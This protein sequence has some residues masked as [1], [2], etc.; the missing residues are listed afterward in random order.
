M[1]KKNEF[2]RRTFLQLAG[3]TA[4]GAALTACA[5]VASPQST[6]A[7]E[8]AAGAENILL[9]IQGN[10]ER[11]GPTGLLFTEVN[12]E[13]EIEF[14]SVTGIDHEEV[15]SKLLSMVAAG[16]PVDGGH[17]CTEATQLYAGQGLSVKL[18]DYILGDEDELMDYFADVSPPLIEAMFY[19]GSLY[20]LARDFNA[21]NMYY[22]TQLFEEAGYGHPESTWTKDDFYEI[23][24]AVT[25]KN[26][27][28]ETEVFGY[29]WIN[30]LWGSWMP[31]IF[32]NEGNLFVEERVEGGEWFW[33][34]FYADDPAA[35]GR[36]GGF[37]WREPVANQTANVEALEFMV[38]LFDEGIAPAV[39]L[40]GG[41]TLQGFFTSNRLAMT[42][43]GGFW[44]GGMHNAGLAPDA[45]DTQLWP[46]WK[47]Q[48][49]QFGV[50]AK[51]MFEQSENKD[52]MWEYMKFEVSEDG[53]KISGYF[54]PFILTTPCRRSMCNEEAFAETGP[55]HWQTFYDTLDKHPTT[56]PIPAPPIA[57]PMTTLFTSYTSR[58]MNKEMTPQE[59]LDGMQDEIVQL[60]D[61]SQDIMYPES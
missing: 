19:E 57:N 58:A 2:S 39:E 43:A 9:R 15:A 28:G 13:V 25:K 18:D 55:I 37:R 38:Q 21:A 51:F 52:V 42:P 59:A 40:G 6:P 36:S 11:E 31:W 27:S 33:S 29:G 41:A 14:I 26:A 53:M 56:A 1:I 3:V 47:S 30:R 45:F 7:E 12:P 44:A 8:G 16:E 5:P 24:K 49:H 35:A 23:A 10:A 17:A 60:V 32:V 61:R 20:Q 4:A 22:N 34:K 50:C 46:A 48:R 54:N